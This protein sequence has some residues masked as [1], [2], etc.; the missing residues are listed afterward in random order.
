M[1]LNSKLP[2]PRRASIEEAM[3][4]RGGKKAG[5]WPGI[6]HFFV[7]HLHADDDAVALTPRL[8]L[9]LLCLLG[10]CIVTIDV[11]PNRLM[12]SLILIQTYFKHFI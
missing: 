12:A 7:N 1:A 4:D 5:R 3:A 11:I 10:R 6:V 9:F 8:S 2:D